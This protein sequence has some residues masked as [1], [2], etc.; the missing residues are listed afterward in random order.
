MERHQLDMTVPMTPD[1]A[2]FA[3][4][5]HGSAPLHLLDRIAFSFAF[6]CASRYT[7]AFAVTLSVDHEDQ[8]AKGCPES[9]ERGGDA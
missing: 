9:D 2:N 6:P 1:R 7:G 5:V 3:G 4:K 8:A